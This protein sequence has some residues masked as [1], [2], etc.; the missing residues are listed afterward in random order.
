MMSPI[1][2]FNRLASTLIAITVGSTGAIAQNKYDAGATDTEIKLGN[3]MPYRG[4]ASAYGAIGK[5]EEA[6]FRMINEAGGINGRKITFITYDDGYNPSKTV[7]QARRLVESDE[8]L[9]M[10]SPMGTPTNSAIQKYL[11]TKKIPHL[12]PASNANKWSD[13]KNFPWTMVRL[14]RGM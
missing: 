3:I 12:F 14:D 4:P 10:F 9:V 13:P 7:E 8:I 5:A 11:N 6:Y 2:R 1:N